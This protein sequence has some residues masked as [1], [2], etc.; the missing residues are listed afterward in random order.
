[1]KNPFILDLE[2]FD[3]ALNILLFTLMPSI[4]KVK[5]SYE[6]ASFKEQGENFEP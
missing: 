4:G 2:G 1:L 5:M 3:V 6:M